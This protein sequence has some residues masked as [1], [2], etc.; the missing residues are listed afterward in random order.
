MCAARVSPLA[1]L[2][3]GFS[4][5]QL[6]NQGRDLNDMSLVL[7]IMIVIVLIGLFVDFLLFGRLERWV[8]ERWGLAT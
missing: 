4:L 5:G 8:N 6:L 1:L 7:A 3:A 2:F